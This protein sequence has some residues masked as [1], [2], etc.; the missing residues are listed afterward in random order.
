MMY[1]RDQ[2]NRQFFW[3]VLG[4]DALSQVVQ[5]QRALT[6]EFAS[7]CLCFWQCRR[8]R[9]H[10]FCGV[11]SRCIQSLATAVVQTVFHASSQSESANVVMMSHACWEQT[12]ARISPA[13]RAHSAPPSRHCSSLN[14]T[15]WPNGILDSHLTKLHIAVVIPTTVIG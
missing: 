9:C 15:C 1:R 10:R 5:P 13:L 8:R 11:S 12:G 2:I 3:K 7:I 14:H 6:H 4:K